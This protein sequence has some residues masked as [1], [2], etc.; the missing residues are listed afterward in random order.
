MKHLL[1]ASLLLLTAWCL[2]LSGVQQAYASH[3]Q[4]GQLTYEYIG[5][6]AQPNRYRVTCRFF[7]DCSGIDAP[8]QLTLNCRVGTP[9]TSCTGND[10]RNFTATL[11]RGL[12]TTGTPYCTSAGNPCGST[13]RTNYETAKYEAVVTLPPAPSWTLSVVEN[14]RPTLANVTGTSQNMYFE[15]VL[16]NQLS[17]ASGGQLAINN[18]SPQYL[19]QDIP[20]PFVCKEQRTTLTFSTFEPDGDS[21]VYSLDRALEDCNQPMTYK[22]MP[23]GGITVISTQ[24]PCVLTLG[25]GGNFSPTFPIPSYTVGGSCP[26]Q[27]GTPSF[28]FNATTG[29]VTFTPY[30]YDA[31]NLANNKYVVVGKVTEFR[32]I[33]GRYYQVGSVRRDM[34]VVVIDCGGNSVPN[35]PVATGVTPGNPNPVNLTD[36]TVVDVFTCNYS[37]VKVRFTDPNAGQQLTVTVPPAALT[38]LDDIIVPNGYVLSGNGTSTPVMTFYFQP[39]PQL[40]G[41]TIRIPVKIEDNACPIKGVQNR[42]IVV[43]VKQGQFATAVAA[44]T[45]PGQ[46][47]TNPIICNGTSLT[48]RGS[49]TRPDSVRNGLQQYSY[50][51][52]AAPG[53]P[54]AQQNS[55]SITVNPTSTTR[56]RLTIAPTIGYSQG[57]GDTTSIVVRVAPRVQAAFRAVWADSV[58][59]VRLGQTQRQPRTFNITNL[60]SV[61]NVQTLVGIDSV[62]WTLQRIKD[63]DGNPV[64]EAARTIHRGKTAL[65]PVSPPAAGVYQLTL[66]VAN[67][68]PGVTCPASLATHLLVVPFQQMPNVFTPNKDGLNDNFVVQPD[69]VGGKV[70]IF[71]RWGRK[72]KE[73]AAYNNDWDGDAQPAGVYYYQVTARDG[74]VTKG[75]VELVR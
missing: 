52:A 58:Q 18:T 6:A 68:T 64:T 53:L 34:L 4:G 15:A 2:A 44:A 22:A 54:A 60:S 36:S 10:S 39:S 3:A 72:V 12:L 67:T 41:T 13:G 51:W 21:L 11:V 31:V 57:C 5:T 7:R 29:S 73:Y 50:R 28:L 8:T 66:S 69:M 9:T 70:V 35:P 1:R 49:V 14:A 75:W 37:Q 56:Y 48:I 63:A 16:N 33:N 71:N 40:V 24:P 47:S 27:V 74:S 17:L 55:Q 61:N 25:A 59:A 38:P 30:Y 42:I 19:D 43:R 23:G 45:A 20:I 32:K 46:S 65:A 26:V 62:K